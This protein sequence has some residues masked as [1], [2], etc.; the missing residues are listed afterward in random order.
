MVEGVRQVAI[1]SAGPIENAN[2]LYWNPNLLVCAHNTRLTSI[3]ASVG[4]MF[5][6]DLPTVQ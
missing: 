6:T 2:E 4:K 3:E 5:L 1:Q